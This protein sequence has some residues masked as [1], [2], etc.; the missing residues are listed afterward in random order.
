MK[1]NIIQKTVIFFLFLTVLNSCKKVNNSN[2]IIKNNE[3]LTSKITNIKIKEFLINN[4]NNT[5]PYK[6]IHINEIIKNLNLN[7]RYS[8][9]LNLTENI[10]IVPLKKLYTN[11]HIKINQFN[12]LRYLI[13][14]ENKKGEL[15]RAD[16]VLFFPKN[17]NILSLPKNSFTNFFNDKTFLVDGTFTLISLGAVKQFEMDYN[18]GKKAKFRVWKSKINELNR[19]PG[20]LHCTSW[21]LVTTTYY[22]DGHIE[23]DWEY[24]GDTCSS[25]APNELCD[26]FEGGGG[27]SG[28]QGEE[29]TMITVDKLYIIKKEL[30]G[31]ENWEIKGSF[32]LD[33][34][35]F[36]NP[37]NNFF[38][39]ISSLGSACIYYHAVT[40]GWI[41]SP[42]YS[43]FKEESHSY[44]LNNSTTAWGSVTASMTYPN[45]G[46]PNPYR[47]FTLPH[48]WQASIELY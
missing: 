15:R 6:N 22:T 5:T 26:V 41:Y 31:T 37:S 24:L 9:V 16:I 32:K 2:F 46:Y 11:H 18:N 21:Y 10:I 20:D 42:S 44:G 7:E 27:G 47:L 48:T 43:I 29:G 1:S 34:V 45:P 30:T 28:G 8:E 4:I 36:S 33:G 25:C 12:V 19:N 40:G 13:L 17:D 38:T 3:V 39:D 14:V 23:V 35:S